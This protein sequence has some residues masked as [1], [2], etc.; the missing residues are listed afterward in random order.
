MVGAKAISENG[1]WEVE[2]KSLSLNLT[3][4]LLRFFTNFSAQ[5]QKSYRLPKYCKPGPDKN[6][7]SQSKALRK[8]NFADYVKE[9]DDDTSQTPEVLPNTNTSSSEPPFILKQFS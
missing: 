9:F 2:L 8:V 4:K 5:Y 7:C 3:P 6:F 1:S